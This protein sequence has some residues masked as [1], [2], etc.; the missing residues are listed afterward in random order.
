MIKTG[1]RSLTR[2]WQSIVFGGAEKS[3]SE[4]VIVVAVGEGVLSVV[5]DSFPD[6]LYIYALK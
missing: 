3:C 5:P 4:T 2:P 1:T 6:S